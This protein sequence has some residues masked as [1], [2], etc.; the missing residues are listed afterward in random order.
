[1]R[2]LSCRHQHLAL[3]AIILSVG[4]WVAALYGFQRVYAQTLSPYMPETMPLLPL[5][6][7]PTMYVAPDGSD[8]TGDGS[9]Y[10]PFLTI[11]KALSQAD[12]GDVID[13]RDGHYF[14]PEG[15]R[16]RRP[17]ITLQSHTGEWAVIQ[18][19]H[20]DEENAPI[21][22]Y[23]D[24]NASHCTLRRLEIIGGYYYGI[25]TETKW[26]WGD[27]N[28]RSGSSQILIE[29]CIVHDTGRDC[30][31]I[32]PNCDDITIRRCEIY[33]SGR[34]YPPGETDGNAEGIDNVN[35]DFVRVQDC[36]IHDTFSTGIYFKGGATCGVVERCRIENCGEA[37]VLVGFDTS[38]EY[39][40]T[41]VNP[42]YYENLYGIVRNCLI[43]NTRYAGIGLYAAYGARILNNTIINAAQE[44]H[45]ALYFGVTFQDW[46]PEA[47]RPASTDAQF[48][49]NLV[50]IPQTSDAPA[51]SIRYADELGG[52]SGLKGLPDM[53]HNLY[54]YENGMARFEDNRPGSQ[55][56]SGDLAQWQTH[57][58]GD[59]QSLEADPLL[60]ADY[61]PTANSPAIDNG[62]ET[63]LVCFDL[64]YQGRKAPFDI[65]AKEYLIST[66]TNASVKKPMDFKLNIFP[67]P[68]QDYLTV[69]WQNPGVDKVYLGLYNILGQRI[70]G[71]FTE[72]Q[73][74]GQQQIRVNT[75]SIPNGLYFISLVSANRHY[76]QK[77]SVCH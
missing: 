46:E 34:I 43:I 35:G 3:T 63:E 9:F 44:A 49:N 58:N 41:R 1:M 22:V 77:L 45:A 62:G 54:Y 51:V 75:K 67:N 30:I 38:P 66:G 53:N 27:P 11:S 64:D 48:L 42:K 7:F 32:K 10:S 33:N 21:A 20:D 12:S 25:S 19:P 73:G 14:E 8:E 26:D 31:K 36:Y 61:T 59:A 47:G 18:A 71:P 52:L 69:T 16:F 17:G 40:D 68:A 5:V 23:L 4:A 39:F 28:D 76:I 60:N 57:I 70:M 50:L 2:S 72:I 15:I 6:P 13:C 65:G 55:L 56:E 24:V 37:G 74:P 29:D